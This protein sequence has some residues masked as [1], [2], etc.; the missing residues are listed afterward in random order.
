[1]IFDVFIFQL[2]S[3][4]PNFFATR[5]VASAR[6]LA[7]NLP[8]NFTEDSVT[9][10][11]NQN[12]PNTIRQKGVEFCAGTFCAKKIDKIDLWLQLV[13]SQDREHLNSNCV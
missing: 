9:E 10:I 2:G 13:K 6:R 11:F 3:I 7:K 4:S 8:F 1:M 5:K 12:L